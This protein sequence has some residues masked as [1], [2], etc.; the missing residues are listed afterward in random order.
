MMRGYKIEV[1][2]DEVRIFR[3][4]GVTPAEHLQDPSAR[5]MAEVV[6][7]GFSYGQP[8]VTV[9]RTLVGEGGS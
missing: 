6:T 2:G 1:Y 5:R 3:E 4:R 8:V 9:S 7:I